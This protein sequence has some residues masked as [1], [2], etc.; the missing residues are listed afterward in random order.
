MQKEVATAAGIHASNYSKIAKGERKPSIEA[1]DKIA[2]LFGM[3]VDE[4]IHFEGKVPMEVKIKDKTVSEKL[5]LIDQLEQAIFRIIE[6]MLT[7]T[8]FKDFFQKNV[9]AL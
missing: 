9:A 5:Q 3:T 7:K 2:K 4:V 8:K 1:L 6:G